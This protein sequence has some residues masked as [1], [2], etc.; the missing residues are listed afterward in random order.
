MHKSG[1]QKKKE[2]RKTEDKAKRLSG[3]LAKYFRKDWNDAA[4]TS[5]SSSAADPETIE[6]GCSNDEEREK[7][8]AKE[9]ERE[10]Q[11]TKED[12]REEEQATKEDEREEEQAT[13][14]DEREE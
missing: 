13:K 10:V 8:E 5:K 11:A 14:E 9:D 4:G 12:E 2:K 6:V 7:G 3:S 1:A